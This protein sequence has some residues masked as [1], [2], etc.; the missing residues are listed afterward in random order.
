[1]I[2]A[3]RA[4]GFEDLDL[5]QHNNG[6]ALGHCHGCGGP[7]ALRKGSAR[8]WCAECRAS[9]KPAAQRQKDL[10][11]RRRIQGGLCQP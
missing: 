8:L 11:E 2:D 5:T 9:G 7:V 3:L 4:F 1:M 10:R 6:Y